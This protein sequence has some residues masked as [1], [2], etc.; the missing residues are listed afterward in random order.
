MKKPNWQKALSD[1]IRQRLTT[2]FAWGEHD[3]CLFA[4]DCAVAMAGIDP[5]EEYRGRYTTEIGAKRILTTT[6]GSI[7]QAFDACFERIEPNS[8]QRGDLVMYES[9]L[10]KTVGV[11]WASE[12]WSAGLNGVGVVREF[13][14]ITAWRID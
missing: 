10:G 11:V 14:P 4:S 12:L 13:A 8:A 3:C 7:E 9:E 5:A 1:L 2:P 6:H